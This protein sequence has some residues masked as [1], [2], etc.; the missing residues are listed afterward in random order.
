MFTEFLK[1]NSAYF[2]KSNSLGIFD[3]ED[4]GNTTLPN[5]GNYLLEYSTVPL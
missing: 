5:D 1:V 3:I 4:G 2:F